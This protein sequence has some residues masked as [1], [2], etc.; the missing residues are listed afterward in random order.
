[1]R[2]LLIQVSQATSMMLIMVLLTTDHTRTPI[3]MIIGLILTPN[4]TNTKNDQFPWVLEEVIKEV[5]YN[6]GF[7]P[8]KVMCDNAGEFI[9]ETAMSLYD[10]YDLFFDPIAP[11]S[12]ESGG[13]WEKCVGDIK[14][15]STTNMIQAPWMPAS[16]WL[17]ADQYAAVYH[18]R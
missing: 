12:P 15:R 1:M 3:T 17:L 7:S 5:K 11:E 6:R 10:A 8:K 18:H 13:L 9:S 16:M 4:G 14:R 2:C